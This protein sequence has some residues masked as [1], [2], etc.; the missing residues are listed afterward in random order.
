MDEKATGP[1]DAGRIHPLSFTVEHIAILFSHS[2]RDMKSGKDEIGDYWAFV[3]NGY[4]FVY[5]RFMTWIYVILQK[6][7]L[8]VLFDASSECKSSLF[9]YLLCSL[10]LYM[11][12]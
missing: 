6:S 8:V 3:G 10:V 11:S 4:N 9:T 5:L 2:W 1:M 12:I 7:A